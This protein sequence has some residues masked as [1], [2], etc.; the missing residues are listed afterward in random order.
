MRLFVAI[1]LS[2]EVRSGLAKVQKDLAAT[3][4]GVRWIPSHQLHLTAKFLGEVPDRD[5]AKVGEAIA[6]AAAG[7]APFDMEIADC[8]CF[9]PR[10]PVRIVWV[11]ANETTGALAGCVEAVETELGRLGFPKERKRFSPHITIGRVREDRS[12]GCLRAAVEA[13]SFSSMQAS[14][15]FITL[16]SSVLS[17]K[18]PTY[19]PVRKADLG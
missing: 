11:G 4:D 3:C 5:V 8:G 19:T 2:D 1:E 16:M 14:I 12:G 15:S 18:G 13:H 6:Q 17:P 7:S 9:P 10:G